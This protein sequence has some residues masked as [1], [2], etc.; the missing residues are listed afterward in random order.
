MALRMSTLISFEHADRESQIQAAFR[1]TLT[2]AA[3]DAE[4][5]I[6]NGLWK[7]ESRRPANMQVSADIQRSAGESTPLTYLCLLLFN[8]NEFVFVD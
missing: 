4:L 2:R 1:R 7:V 6:A 8:G 3:T 5:A